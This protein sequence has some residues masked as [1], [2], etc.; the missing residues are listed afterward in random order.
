[1]PDDS[2]GRRELAQWIVDPA[3]PLTSRV[4]V[5]RVWHWLIG[6]GLV[7]TVDNFGTTGESPSHPK[8]LDHLAVQFI[9]QGWSVKKLIRTIVRSRTYRLSSSPG[10]QQGDPENRLLAHMNRRRLDAE[11]LRDTMLSVGGALNLEMGGATFPPGLKSDVGFQFT[12]PRRS[13]YVP[14]F[15]SSL[16]ELFE[17]F[18]FA[19]PS[20]V[21]GRRD[22]STVAP[23]ALYMMNHEFVR[24]QSRLTAERL[25]RDVQRST[26]DRID[27]AYL[28]TLGRHAT[29]AEV[30][31]SQQFVKSVS[32]RPGTPRIDAWAQMVQSMFSSI[33]FRYVR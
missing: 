22:V 1:M 6:A 16:P 25:L 11:S 26:S 19:N 24:S 5:N 14:V 27:H 10:E 17:V 3:N 20:L 12:S 2:S 23:Q 13:V 8:L 21:T 28:L 32:D 18:D 15:R 29:E 30:T 9:H 33:Q 4:M 7:R 31:L